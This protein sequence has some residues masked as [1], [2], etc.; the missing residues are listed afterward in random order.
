MATYKLMYFNGRGL[1]ELSR[2][3]FEVA[4]QPYDDFR[5]EFNQWADFKPLMPFGRPFYFSQAFRSP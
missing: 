2:Y 5:Y 1:A 3:I 4:G